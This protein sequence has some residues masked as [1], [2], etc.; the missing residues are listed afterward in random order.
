MDRIAFIL[1]DKENRMIFLFSLFIFEIHAT[2]PDLDINKFSPY[3][4]EMSAFWRERGEKSFLHYLAKW[5]G[6]GKILL[7]EWYL[8]NWKGPTL[9]LQAC[10]DFKCKVRGFLTEIFM[11]LFNSQEKGFIQKWSELLPLHFTALEPALR[12][13][14]GETH[15]NNE[16][17]R[18]PYYLPTALL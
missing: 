2:V 16:E 14:G 7:Q 13:C 5:P 10:H 11:P 8:N 18:S 15:F 17:G 3:T 6:D 9:K 12:D 1:F 4:A